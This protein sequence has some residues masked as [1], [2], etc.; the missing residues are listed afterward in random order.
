MILPAF[1][2]AEEGP[3]GFGYGTVS[4]SDLGRIKMA[5]GLGDAHSIKQGTTVSKHG[6]WPLYVPLYAQLSQ[7]VTNISNNVVKTNK[8]SQGSLVG[9]MTFATNT[10]AGKTHRAPQGDLVWTKNGW[11]NDFYPDGFTN[12]LSVLGSR[13]IAPIKDSGVRV[14]DMTNGLLVLAE[15]NLPEPFTNSVFLSTNSVLSSPL[16]NANTT[17]PALSAKFGV[18]KGAFIHPANNAKPT[19]FFGAIL[20]DYNYGRGYFAG[21]NETGSVR[22]DPE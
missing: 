9:W 19:K 16:P 15:G 14:M 1:D 5:G 12:E 4:V 18:L 2:N 21:T 8:E 7:V 17:K 3:T 11:T 6:V 22:L 20:Q 10:P 13:H